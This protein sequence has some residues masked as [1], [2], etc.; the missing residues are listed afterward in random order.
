MPGTLIFA[1]MRMKN[2]LPSI[3]VKWGNPHYM[4]IWISCYLRAISDAISLQQTGV[5]HY[6]H[7]EMAGFVPA[8]FIAGCSLGEFRTRGDF[9][10]LVRFY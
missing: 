4:R 1:S 9:T 7:P 3:P 5:L 10:P 6:L 2:I 8:S